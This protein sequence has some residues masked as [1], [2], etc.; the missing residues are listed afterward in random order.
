MTPVT[1]KSIF[2]PMDASAAAHT[3]LYVLC[4][5]SIKDATVKKL[6]TADIGEPE[7]VVAALTTEIGFDQV[8]ETGLFGVR[9]S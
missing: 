8:V 4:G 7:S 5:P 2:G 6:S 9:V 3:L 1:A